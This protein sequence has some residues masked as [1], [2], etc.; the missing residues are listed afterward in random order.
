MQSVD[1]S[2]VSAVG[3]NKTSK[4]LYVDWHKGGRYAYEGVTKELHEQVISSNSIGET[5]N[6]LKRSITGRK[7]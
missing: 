1:S 3:Y 7:V 2:A 5:M 4:T 6:Y